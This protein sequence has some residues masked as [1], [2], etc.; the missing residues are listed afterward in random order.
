MASFGASS[1]PPPPHLLS[2][3]P[4]ERIDSNPVS[5][6]FS[7]KYEVQIYCHPPNS[8]TRSGDFLSSLYKLN[9]GDKRGSEA[10]DHRL[11]S[12]ASQTHPC[13]PME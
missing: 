11:D 1:L 7:G 12:G 2:L 4:N 5:Y 13:L 8:P 9:L 3:P 6:P 10:S